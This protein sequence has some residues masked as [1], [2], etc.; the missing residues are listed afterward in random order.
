MR[1]HNKALV[2]KIKKLKSNQKSKQACEDI[3]KLLEKIEETYHLKNHNQNLQ[4]KLSRNDEENSSLK[5][6][7]QELLEQIKKLREDENCKKKSSK[8]YNMITHY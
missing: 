8:R 7:N 4:L 6:V 2:T 3:E 5:R 1:T